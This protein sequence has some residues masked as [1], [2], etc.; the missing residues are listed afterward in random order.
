SKTGTGQRTRMLVFRGLH[1]FMEDTTFFNIVGEMVSAPDS[2]AALPV[3]A[4]AN[5]NIIS[6]PDSGASFKT[7]GV[8]DIINSIATT[9]NIPSALLDIPRRLTAQTPVESYYFW[10]RRM[11]RKMWTFLDTDLKAA[12]DWALLSDFMTS[13]LNTQ[14]L[15]PSVSLMEVLRKI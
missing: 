8:V 6:Q 5:G 7:V 14:G 1:G 3:A 2:S 9:Q 10:A 4:R 15:G 13:G 11:D 12:W